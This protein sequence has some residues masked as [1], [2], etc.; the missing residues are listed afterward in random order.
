MVLTIGQTTFLEG[1]VNGH[2][3]WPIMKTNDRFLLE[4][5]ITSPRIFRRVDLNLTDKCNC[6]LQVTFLRLVASVTIIAYALENSD[7]DIH[8][9]PLTASIGIFL[10]IE[11][12]Y[13]LFKCNDL[14]CTLLL[15]MV[16]IVV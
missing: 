3:Q 12:L 4:I 10:L 11:F 16:C 8:Q 5:Q 9:S 13:S 1:L 15:A 2:Y 6:S 7:G 14:L